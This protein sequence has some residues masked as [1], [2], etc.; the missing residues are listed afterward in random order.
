MKTQVT[1]KGKWERELEVEVPADRVDAEVSTAVAKYRKR[2]EIP[3]FRKGKVPLKVVE[4][5][6]G[7]SIR[8]S[9]ISDLLPELV[10]E[11]TREA[12]LVPAAA[13]RI[14]K[15]DHEPGKPL[16]FTASLDIWPEVDLENYEHLSVTK[17]VHEVSDEEVEEQLKEL[18]TRQA[19]ERPVDRPLEKGDVLIADLQR[20]D[21]SGVPLVGEKFEE[22]YFIIGS[23]DAPSP[24]F[25][26]AL[27]G[28]KA[29]ETRNVT[30]TYRSDLPN[31]ELAGKIQHFAVTVR[32]VRERR[33]PDL[34]DEFAKDLGDQFDSLEALRTHVSEQIADRWNYLAR[35]RMR[36]EVLDGLI[37]KNPFDLPQGLIENYLETLRKER[38]ESG[39]H[40]HHDHHD[41]DHDHDHDHEADGGHSQEDRQ[42]AVRRLKTYLLLEAV[43]KDA[44]IEL[45]E[46]HLDEHLSEWAERAGV[47]LPELKRSPRAENLRRE[48]EDEKVFEYLLET[49]DIK[50]ERV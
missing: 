38:D 46:E 18:R 17:L 44:G 2:L 47:K 33:L 24:E 32:E 41:H 42:N 13:P 23:D 12:G 19:T 31:E 20:L 25:E 8:S 15:L 22:R 9:V 30:F 43:R 21:E 37:K 49:A 16:S 14:T 29:D 35:Q 40:D 7:D 48:L 45:S 10:Q 11:A 36:G 27:I 6:Y 5:R 4:S 28:V 39:S 34:D 3:G 50:E 1:E 26:E